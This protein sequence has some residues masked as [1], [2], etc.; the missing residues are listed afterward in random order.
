MLS[1][2]LFHHDMFLDFFG[3]KCRPPAQLIVYA[4]PHVSVRQEPMGG[5]GGGVCLL[6][7]QRVLFVDTMA[8]LVTRC[9]RSLA[10]LARLPEIDNVFIVP[11]LR[12]EIDRLR[13]SGE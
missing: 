4:R 13:A 10:D 1:V 3:K 7:G 6:K 9:D 12:D 8:D 5:D 2:N 11:E